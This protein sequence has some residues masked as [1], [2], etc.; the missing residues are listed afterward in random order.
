MTVTD[1]PPIISRDAA[2]HYFYDGVQYPG[3][4][5]ILDVLDKSRPLMTWAARQTAEAALSLMDE[6]KM[7][8]EWDGETPITV[9]T[10]TLRYL[11]DTV[12]REGTLKALTSR[13]NWKRD[14]AAQLGTEVHDLADRMIRGLKLPTMT[15]TQLARVT[16]Y[17]EWWKAEQKQ[18]AKLRLSEAMILQPNYADNPESGWGG[19]FDLLYYDADG[20]TVLADIK[21]GGKW[22]RKVY[23]SEVLQVTAY[24][25]GRLVQPSTDGLTLPSVYPMPQVDKYKVIH[26]TGEGCKAIP[27]DVTARDRMAFL[28]CLDLHHWVQNLKGKIG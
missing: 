6:P 26:V 11:L 7:V 3:V 1:A 18:G 14:E 23:E 13:S 9:Q 12:G 25:M 17:R 16:H 21:T 27:V 24:G 22:G 10:T 2:H 5:T 15:E 19:T 8:S 20:A 4:T 28:A